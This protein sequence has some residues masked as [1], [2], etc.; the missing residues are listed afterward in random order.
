MKKQIVIFGQYSPNCRGSQCVKYTF[1]C[2]CKYSPFI[3][4]YTSL[5]GQINPLTF[6]YALNQTPFFNTMSLAQ[7][8]VQ[9][10]SFNH[11]ALHCT[12]QPM[13]VSCLL[14]FFLHFICIYFSVCT[15]MYWVSLPYKACCTATLK[16]WVLDG[17]EKLNRVREREGGSSGYPLVNFKCNQ[18]PSNF[19]NCII[20]T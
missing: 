4:K 8:H 16:R 6:A 13:G 5:F 19:I 2:D 18:Q 11:E 1:F 10:C 17:R 14:I 20:I 12:T 3:Y 9:C 15:R 7:I